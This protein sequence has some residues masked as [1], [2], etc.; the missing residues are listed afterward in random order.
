MYKLILILSVILSVCVGC[1]KEDLMVFEGKVEEIYEGSLIITTND[2]IGFDKASVAISDAMIEGEIEVGSSLKITIY[3]EVA[4]SYPVQVTAVQV[5][6][7]G[8][9]YHKITSE[10]A[11]EMMDKER[12]DTIIDVRTLEEYSEGHITDAVLLPSDEVT[13]KA[14]TILENKDAVILIYCRSGK[15]SEAAAKILVDKGYTNVY[16]FGGI[17][18]WLYE[19]VQ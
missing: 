11:K 17:I 2:D 16:D 13:D 12:Y 5:E 14:E 19:I 6:V 4:E 7:V 18:D 1:A 8:A 3:P 9:V 15:R 10:E